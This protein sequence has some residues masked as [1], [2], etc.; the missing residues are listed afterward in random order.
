M[1]VDDAFALQLTQARKCV[2]RPSELTP[3]T[4]GRSA[5]AES[6]SLG[7][8]Q[9]RP[10]SP[11]EELLASRRSERTMGPV[12]LE[13]VA[14]LLHSVCAVHFSRRGPQGLESY[15]AHPSAGARHPLDL[16]LYAHAVVGLSPGAWLLDAWAM[17]LTRLDVHVD[18]GRVVAA[19]R[20]PGPPPLTLFACASADRTLTRYPDGATLV[21]R[22]A[23][24]FLGYLHLAAFDMGHASCIV[25]TSG[26]VGNVCALPGA[27]DVGALALGSRTTAD[28]SAHDRSDG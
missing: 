19:L 23:G 25:G 12:P 14:R 26:V 6:L 27:V 5:T 11:L 10:P 22:D 18:M 8:V 24:V 3:L 7:V 28:G 21:W 16:V 4:D 1:S 9:P 13:D 20:T 17:K 2:P 15:R